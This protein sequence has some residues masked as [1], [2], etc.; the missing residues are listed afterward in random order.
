MFVSLSGVGRRQIA[1][2]LTAVLS[3]NSV[4]V[5]SAGTAA[6]GEIDPG[7]RTVIAELAVDTDSAFARPVT[8]EVL[9]AADVIVTMATASA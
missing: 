5:H 6:H 9:R 2:A 3:E 8:D 4:A 1:A 7:V